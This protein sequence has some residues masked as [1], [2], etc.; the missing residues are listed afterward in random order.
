MVAALRRIGF[1]KVFDTD[2]AADLT[3][4]EEAHEFVERVKNGGDRKSVV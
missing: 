1:D 2:F 4:V 3:I